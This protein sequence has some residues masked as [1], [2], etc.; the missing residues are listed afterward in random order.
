MKRLWLLLLLPTACILDPC[1][2]PLWPDSQDKIRVKRID[3][4]FE[5]EIDLGCHVYPCTIHGTDSVQFAVAL[6]AA[7]HGLHDLPD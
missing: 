1:D 6:C 7:A 5:I 4:G 3:D 2:S